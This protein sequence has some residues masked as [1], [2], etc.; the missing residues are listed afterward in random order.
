MRARLPALGLAARR[1]TARV[2]LA[3]AGRVSCN[4]IFQRSRLPTPASLLRPLPSWL[5][6]EA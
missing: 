2:H 4:L 5:Q 1:T 6:Q 3:A